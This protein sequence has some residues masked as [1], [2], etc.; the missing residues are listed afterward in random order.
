MATQNV[1][2]RPADRF[3]EWG[4]L[5]FC[6]ILSSISSRITLRFSFSCGCGCTYRYGYRYHYGI[7]GTDWTC[8]QGDLCAC[9][10]QTVKLAETC[11]RSP[12]GVVPWLRRLVAGLSPPIPGLVRDQSTWV[13]WW[14]Q[15]QDFL[16]YCCFACQYLSTSAPYSF[17]NPLAPELFFLILAHL[18]IKCE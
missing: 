11:T 17:I 16:Q 2:R 9:M 7:C 13:L 10:T 14:T 8:R 15:W 12:R 4:S 18:Y 3:S 1:K 6:E 5:T